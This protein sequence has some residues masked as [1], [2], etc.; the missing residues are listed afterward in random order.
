MKRIAALLPHLSLALNLALL[1]VVILD[2]FHPLAG[3][4]KGAAFL[5]LLSACVLSS[6][7]TA[8]LLILHQRAKDRQSLDI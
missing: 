4:L 3:L 2:V 6:L 1:T 7:V 8:L 5:I